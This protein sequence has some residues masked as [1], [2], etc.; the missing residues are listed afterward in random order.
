MGNELGVH[1]PALESLSPVWAQSH[2]QAM[3][4]G[5]LAHIAD[6][7]PELWGTER[8]TPRTLAPRSPKEPEGKRTVCGRKEQLRQR[9][10]Q[11]GL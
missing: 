2:H 4:A 5:C 3:S 10:S 1:S 7:R 9:D 11:Q 6:M 8:C